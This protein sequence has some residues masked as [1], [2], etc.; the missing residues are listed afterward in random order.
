VTFGPRQGVTFPCRRLC[1][2]PIVVSMNEMRGGPVV[3]GYDSSPAAGRAMD[4]AAEEASAFGVPLVLVHVY[5]WPILWATLANVP[6]AAEQWRPAPEAVA[7]AESAAARLRQAHP[8]LDVST[9]VPVG[10]GGEQLVAASAHASLLVVGDTGTRGLSGVLTGSVTPYV[11]THAHCPVMVVRAA[12][13][14]AAGRAGGEVCVGVD[15][16]PSSLDA[17]RFAAGWARRRG[18]TLRALHA[19]G[20]D[21]FDGGAPEFGGHTLAETRLH[22]WVSE[23]LG[24][25]AVVDTAILRRDP[26]GALVAASAAA[27]LVVVGSRHRG[28]LAS[29]VLGSVGHTL[30]RRAACP[31]VIVPTAPVSVSPDPV[32]ART[33]EATP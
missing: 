3:V 6:F 16:T 21:S 20:H 31:V 5:S 23:G 27:R 30:I 9:S 17:L 25:G 19:I 13:P 10:K 15:G 14:T 22:D 33:P 29:I 32:A 18:L 2:D 24:D 4:V 28:E 12:A 8:G 26:A 7:A 11:M 1:R